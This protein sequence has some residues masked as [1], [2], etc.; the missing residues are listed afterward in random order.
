M[1]LVHVELWYYSGRPGRPSHPIAPGGG[2]PDQGLPPSPGHPDQGLPGAPGHPDQ[3]LPPGSG[4]IEPPIT[5]PPEIWPPVGPGRPVD[6]GFGQRPPPVDPG[7]GIIEGG[8]PGHP[9]PPSPGHPDQGLPPS[10][11]HPGNRPP[12]SFPEHPSG[13]PVP[14][15]ATTPPAQP[16]R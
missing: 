10:P 9:L 1:A 13:Q 6:P 14:P 7:W 4:V 11:G 5:L 2:H 8:H 12:G 15:P 16:K 3:G